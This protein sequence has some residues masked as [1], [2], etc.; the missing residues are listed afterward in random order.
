MKP[1]LV[2]LRRLVGN[3]DAFA[4][5]NPDG[6]WQPVRQP[7]TDAVL[8]RHLKLEWTVGTYI[9]HNVDGFG[10]VA[11]TLVFDID[12]GS[13]PP[14]PIPSVLADFG[15]APR[16]MGVEVSG[17]K[18]YHV[19]FV[20]RDYVP[21][22]ELR[23]LGRLVL[24]VADINCEVFPKQDE[25]R[26][27]GNL[28]KLPGGK[29]QVTGNLNDFIDDVPLPMPLDA[30]D[31]LLSTLPPELNARRTG[32]TETRYPCMDAIL[33]EGVAEGGRN[34]QLFHLAVMLRRGG[35]TAEYVENV[36]RS[37]NDKCTPPL[38]DY[39]LEKVLESSEFSGPLC[40]SIPEDRH[41]GDAC[42]SSR[43]RGL[44]CRVGQLSRSMPGELVVVEVGERK[45]KTLVFQHPDI[46][47]MR[48]VIH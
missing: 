45:G 15:V 19:W 4:V 44:Q 7:L 13:E 20:L 27:L 46:V 42:V 28:V 36:V 38:E 31:V 21:S 29:H 40:S 41:C 22:A 34:N 9:G 47:K 8:E 16:F 35:L 11:R 24:A 25:V 33:T 30:W 6:T 23:R 14:G 43:A 48:G 26:D 39:E 32:T 2:Q 10:T 5:Q 1:N 3:P 18:G 17:R 12:D 37:V